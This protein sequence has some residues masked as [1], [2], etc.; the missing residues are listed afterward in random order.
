MT[1]ARL[2]T[3]KELRDKGAMVLPKLDLDRQQ[4][5]SA[6]AAFLT[7]EKKNTDSCKQCRSR[8]SRGPC[9]ECI[10]GDDDLFNGA[11]TN[12]QFSS[13]AS[14]CSFYKGKLKGRLRKFVQG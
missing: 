2:I 9:S 10:A 13:T 5:M 3:L 11:C 14:A 12:C 4:K 6:L 8:K 1:I 7:V